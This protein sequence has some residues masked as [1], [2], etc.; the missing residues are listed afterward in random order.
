MIGSTTSSCPIA[1]RFKLGTRLGDPPTEASVFR[2]RPDVRIAPDQQQL[3]RQRHGQGIRLNLCIELR[4]VRVPAQA[5]VFLFA[6]HLAVKWVSELGRCRSVCVPGLPK[7]CRR[8]RERA[9]AVRPCR[10]VAAPEPVHPNVTSSACFEK[11]A[12]TGSLKL[13]FLT[14][15]RPPLLQYEIWVAQMWVGKSVSS[16]NAKQRQ[17]EGELTLL[18]SY[19]PEHSTLDERSPYVGRRMSALPPEQAT[20][21]ERER[22]HRNSLTCCT[23]PLLQTSFLQH[24]RGN[25]IIIIACFCR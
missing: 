1:F 3:C 10:R 15:A 7:L 8:E 25:C 4:S 6:S 20:E 22:D 18:L 17:R 11:R 9:R 12:R 19:R 5:I 23:N 13:P 24:S 16:A 14:T 21:R 2:R